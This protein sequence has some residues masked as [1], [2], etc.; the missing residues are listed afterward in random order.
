MP[1]GR[2]QKQVEKSESL[3]DR[4]GGFARDNPVA[5]GGTLVMALTGSLIVANAIGL[6]PGRHPA[7]LFAT[8]DQGVELPQT[9]EVAPVMPMSP[10]VLDIQHELRNRGLYEGPLDGVN[11]PAT[12][13]AIRHMQRD[14]GKME[15]GEATEALLAAISLNKTG[16]TTTTIQPMTTYVPIPR[17][18]PGPIVGGRDTTLDEPVVEQPVRNARLA[19]IQRLLSELGYGPLVADGVMGENTS[20]AIR[21]FELD[22]GLSLSGQPSEEVVRLLEK[23]SGQR[24]SN[25]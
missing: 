12:E 1:R 19:A 25:Q 7:P 23:V 6:Q 15:T 11:G 13:R 10:L 3:V 16:P 2:G 21:R 14:L 9:V 8:R 17:R 20:I 18:K 4:A 5:A 22:R 24:I